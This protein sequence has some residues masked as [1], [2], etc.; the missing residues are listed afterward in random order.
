MRKKRAV[1]KTRVG[2]DAKKGESTSQKEGS[3]EEEIKTK[4]DQPFTRAHCTHSF[5]CTW[6]SG[7][8]EQ[9]REKKRNCAFMQ[10]LC[11]SGGIVRKRRKDLRNR[12]AP[13]CTVTRCENA[14]AAHCS[15]CQ[16]SH[17]VWVGYSR[18]FEQ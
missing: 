3:K 11:T 2:S 17:L 15:V 9:K 12:E 13:R 1:R 8:H 18:L 5:D 7:Q 16:L 6:Y 14:I 4:H 10:T